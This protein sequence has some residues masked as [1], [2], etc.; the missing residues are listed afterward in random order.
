MSLK[1]DETSGANRN[2]ICDMLRHI[3]PEA[4][5]IVAD[6]GSVVPRNLDFCTQV[7][8]HDDLAGCKCCC[9]IIGSNNTVRI[10][11]SE[12]LKAHGGGRTIAANND[13]SVNGAGSDQTVEIEVKNRY[14]QRRFDTREWLDVPDW[15]ILAHELCG[16]ALP[17]INGYEQ[18]WRPGKPG[19]RKDWHRA[20]E[21]IEDDLRKE[22][23]L[24]PRGTEHGVKS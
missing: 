14:G 19:Y 8:E 21:L 6:D 11:V 12:D 3:Y 10:K 1:I 23:G 18:E 22:L 13:D 4:N 2:A 15:L 20:S 24:P 17:G 5:F 16:H 9:K 7:L